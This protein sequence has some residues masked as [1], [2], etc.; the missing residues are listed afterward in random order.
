MYGVNK[1]IGRS[2]GNLKASCTKSFTR[3]DNGPVANRRLLL[4]VA[5]LLLLVSIAGALTPREDT[6]PEQ[7]V[8]AKRPS[9]SATV[10]GTLPRPT[11]VRARVGD[12]VALRVR[13]GTADQAELPAFGLSEPVGPDLVAEFTFI[14]D[15]PGRFPVRLSLAGDEAGA[16]IVRRR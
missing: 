4:L 1:V 7:P 12:L 14:A 2:L 3:V 13:S 11:A 8:T 9:A 15:R 6:T 10:R 16:L 5:A